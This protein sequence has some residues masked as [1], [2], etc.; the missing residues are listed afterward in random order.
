MNNLAGILFLTGGI[1]A[2]LIVS[3]FYVKYIMKRHIVD[4][5]AFGIL[6]QINIAL[7]VREGKS[8]NLVKGMEQKI[9]KYLLALNDFDKKGDA[10]LAMQALKLY[11]KKVS[12]KVPKEIENLFENIPQLAIDKSKECF[13]P[14]IICDGGTGC[15]P[16][17]TSLR[18]TSDTIDAYNGFIRGSGCGWKLKPT[19]PFYEDCGQPL[20][21]LWCALIPDEPAPS[22][23][24]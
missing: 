23:E 24:A 15:I 22:P 9:P 12:L 4:R 17:P 8:E 13:V 7:L 5:Y 21:K 11:C 3:Y 18:P 20:T 2:G 16:I 14:E 6:E 1:V 19:W 10:L